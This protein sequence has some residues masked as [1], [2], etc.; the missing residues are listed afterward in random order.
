MMIGGQLFTRGFL[1]EGIRDHDA[2]RR[3]GEAGVAEWREDLTRLVSALAAQRAPNE[4][5]TE[6]RLIYPVLES[7]GWDHRDVQTNASVKGREDVPDALLFS[8]PETLS[9]AAGLEPWRR[10]QHGLCIVEAK[11]W[12]RLLDRETKGQKGEEGTPSSQMLRYLRR[13]EERT[14]GKLRW[15][16][17]TNGRLWRLYHHTGTGTSENYLEIDLG[18]ALNAPGCEPD[19]LDRPPDGFTESSWRDH[20]LRLFRVLFGR[21]SFLPEA[22]GESF[23]QLA[24]RE[25]KRW[26]AKVAKTLSEK[27]FG[28]VFPAL[29]D[30]L[31]KSGPPRQMP[32]SAADLDDIRQGALILLYRLLFVLYAEDR[33]LL[34]DEHGPYAEFCLT[35]I[36]MEVAR[37]H[38]AGTPYPKGVN[39]IWPRLKTIFRAIAEGNDDLGIPPYNGGLFEASAAPILETVDLP[40]AALARALFALSHEPDTGQGARY[41]NYRDL[42]VQQLGSVYER[43]LEYKLTADGLDIKVGLSPFGRKSSGSYYTPDELVQ[44]IIGRTVGPL[45][46]EAE[47][48]FRNKAESGKAHP[49]ELAALDPAEAILRLKV[50]DPAMGSGHFLVTLVDWM[51]DRVLEA[52]ASAELTAPGYVSPVAARIETVRGRIEKLAKDHN[53]PIVEAHLDNKAVVRRMVLKR[54]IYGVD[55]NPMAVEL[56]KVALWLHSFTVGAPL[57]FLDHHLICGNALFGERVR[58]VMD[59]AFG[60]NLLINDMVQKARGAARGMEQVEQLTDADVAEVRNSKS[61]FGD[62]QAATE[63]LRAFMDLVHGLRWAGGDKTRTRAIARLQKGDFGNPLALLTGRISPPEVS[64]SQRKLLDGPQTGLSAIDRKSLRDAEDLAVLPAILHDVRA[65]IARERFLHWEVAFPGVWSDWDSA[66]PSGGFD[67]VIGNPPWDRMKFQEVEWFAERR[68]DIAMAT[69]AADRKR[70]V[71]QLVKTTEPIVADYHAAVARAEGSA[72][73]ARDC[74]AYPL[75]SSGDINLYSLFVERSHMLV[76]KSGML[77]LLVPIGIGTD[78]NSAGYI[79]DIVDKRQL[80]SFISFENRRR[81][82]FDDVHAEDQPTVLIVSNSSRRSPHFEYAVKLHAIPNEEHNPIIVLSA[83]TLHAVNPNTRTMPIFRSGE[84]SRIITDVYKNTPIFVRRLGKREE[85]DW[86]TYY[87]SMFHLTN[88]SSLFRNRD[89]VENREGGWPIGQQRFNSPSGI[90]LPLYEGKSIQIYNHRYASVVTPKGSLSGQ[91]QSVHSTPSELASP[92]FYPSPRY[93]VNA[94][95][96]DTVRLGY[97]IGF[98]DVCN[99]NNARSVIAAIIPRVAAGNS[100]PILDGLEADQCALLLANLNSIPCDYIARSK[101]Q[102]RHLN[103]YILEQLPIIPPALYTRKFGD[104]TSAEIVREHVL[105]LSYTARDLSPFARDMGYIDPATGEARPPFVFDAAD[106]LRRRARLDATYFMLYFPSVTPADVAT[107]RDTASYIYSTFPIVEREE[108]AAHGRYLSRD[109]W[110]A[111]G[112]V[113]MHLS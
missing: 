65:A 108:M 102:S 98:N 42:S 13:V 32:L 86:P 47:A 92:D 8:G 75:L 56:A 110:P 18:K 70:M 2:W 36:R 52:M 78:A 16:I 58:P 46:D 40:D 109:L 22:A 17:L 96:V 82:L 31:A 44:L 10:F 12:G 59:W 54:C 74:G 63:D 72:K 101:I 71:A 51:T 91:G 1:Q 97:A 27:V 100:L 88:S 6:D 39:L 60:G 93:W 30:A 19:L 94:K 21:H 67:A 34:P 64:A 55:L 3:S 83:Q 24:L 20:V 48:A 11:R 4:A 50:C 5:Q 43:L 15:G 76:K 79:A 23:H 41:I 81:W 61:L 53:W 29:A 73:V 111:A 33:N 84:D 7:L 49:R 25:G 104:K 80:K 14:Q 95:E 66:E 28:E 103:K 90:W 9:L 99:T 112:S 62:V 113:D 68:P 57:S 106:R 107:L 26:E 105:V 38:E 35:R 89:E 37:R 45:A 87:L 85:C 69:R 77:G